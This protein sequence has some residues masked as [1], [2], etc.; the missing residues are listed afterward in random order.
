MLYES[1]I[2]NLLLYEFVLNNIDWTAI[3]DLLLDNMVVLC[4]MNRICYEFVSKIVI[5]ILKKF[6][7]FFLQFL[8]F[9]LILLIFCQSQNLAR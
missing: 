4:R 8:A 7:K 2:I 1:C 5:N 3:F 6:M 9:F